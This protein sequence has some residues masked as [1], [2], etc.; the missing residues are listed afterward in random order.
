LDVNAVTKAVRAELP[1][2]R[3]LDV[4]PG[5]YHKDPCATPSLSSTTAH[6]LVSESPLHAWAAHPRN[7]DAQLDE[8]N[9]DDADDDTEATRNGSLVHT[10]LLGKGSDIEVIEADSF[11]TKAAR[12]ARDAAKAAGK[13]PIIAPKYEEIAG[14][15]EKLRNR[16]RDRGFDLTGESEVAIEWYEHGAQGPIVCRSML[17]H[18]FVEHGVIWD[19]KT[20]RSANPRR[21]RRS[22]VD[23]GYDVQ[24]FAYSRALERLRPALTGRVQFLFLFMELQSPFAITPIEPDGAFWEIGKQRWTRAVHL[25]ETCRVT[26]KWPAYTESVHVL[27]AP[28]YVIS[29]HLGPEWAA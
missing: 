26:N 3:I 21:L 12:E 10:L 7:E 15:A 19:L 25:W 29:E 16:L 23:Y 13:I 24:A 9:T 4:T 27:E 17:D 28:Q 5:E 6:K 22:F 18:V 2:A 20:C 14:V 8:D 1:A 11:R